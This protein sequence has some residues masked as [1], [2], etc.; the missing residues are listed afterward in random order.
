M[1]WASF[2]VPRALGL[3]VVSYV[4]VDLERKKWSDDENGIAAI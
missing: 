4:T 2:W 3:L 1:C